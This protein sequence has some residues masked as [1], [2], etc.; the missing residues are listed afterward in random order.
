[1]LY[2]SFIGPSNATGEVLKLESW[3]DDKKFLKIKVTIMVY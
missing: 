1:M 2:E 3:S